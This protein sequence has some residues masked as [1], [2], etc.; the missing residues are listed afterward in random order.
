M[1]TRAF[2][3]A[4]IATALFL[5]GCVAAFNWVVDPYWYFRAFDIVGFNHVRRHAE[6]NER[7]VKPALVSRLRPQAV[8]LGNS[9]AE[10]GLPPSNAGFT[11]NGALT[12]YNLALP[13]G[14]WNEIYCLALYVMRSTD[15]RRIVIGVS[16]VHHE[17]GDETCP[18]DSAFRRPDY[19]KL[20][21][22]RSAF[23]AS[24]ETL[25][26]QNQ[27]PTMTA[28]GNWYFHR[29][30]DDPRIHDGA[31]W[32]LARVIRR[33][34]CRNMRFREDA[35]DWSLVRMSPVPK[36]VG[37][38]LRTLIRTAREKRIEL[39]LLYYPK[40]VVLNEV[41]RACQ[42]HESHWN[43]L[44]AMVS[45]AEQE[46]DPQLTQVWDFETYVPTNAERLDGRSPGPDLL[47][48]EAQHFNQAVGAAAM[49]A[50]YR[51]K[52]GY[53]DRVTVGNFRELVE[54]RE[55]ERVRFLETN[56]WVREEFETFAGRVATVAVKPTR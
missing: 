22:S 53:G 14:T 36:D 30:I 16:S 9:V 2:S 52:P 39:V 48:Q 6:A 19:A 34:L 46:G 35:L 1:T 18:S 8:I 7:L 40:H 3:L 21:F 32:A 45:I 55:V 42:G 27:P 24:R 50:I 28:D 51:G 4:L 47:W 25:R 11:Q 37:A 33:D 54:R 5:V 13:G 26:D 10:I 38:G 56:P 23:A 15:V 31:T 49:D 12:S 29:F 41:Q 44:W 43:E 17:A 20:L